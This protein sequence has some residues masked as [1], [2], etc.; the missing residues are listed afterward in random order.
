MPQVS[1]GHHR[2][3][4]C[5]TRWQSTTSTAAPNQPIRA[6]NADATGTTKH[7]SKVSDSKTS[8]ASS[9]PEA[10]LGNANVAHVFAVDRKIFPNKCCHTTKDFSHDNVFGIIHVINKGTKPI[11][12]LYSQ[13]TL[14]WHGTLIAT[15]S[16]MVSLDEC[17][18]STCSGIV[19]AHQ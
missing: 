9:Q 19:A 13:I 15:H 11:S 10:A 6:L 16:G 5:R 7:I 12:S 18:A 8:T 14:G 4:L 1:P 2:V 17:F 3:L